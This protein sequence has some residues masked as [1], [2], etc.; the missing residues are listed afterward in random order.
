MKKIKGI[1]VFVLTLLMCTTT[2]AAMAQS[3]Q[4]VN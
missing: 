4:K 1:L 3:H 2:L